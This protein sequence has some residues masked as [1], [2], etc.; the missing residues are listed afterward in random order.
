[1]S[2]HQPGPDSAMTTAEHP[3]VPQIRQALHRVEDPEI[4]RP[5]TDLGMVD[6]IAVDT[7]GRSRVRV[8]LTVPGARYETRCAATS[9]PRLVRC[10]ESR[11]WRSTWA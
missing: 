6:D 11:R 1:M 7:E 5:I 2:D 9:P 8:L 10:P 4:R 3:L